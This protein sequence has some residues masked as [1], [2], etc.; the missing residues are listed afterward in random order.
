[1]RARVNGVRHAA[2][3]C[4]NFE[5]GWVFLDWIS[6][7]P[8]MLTMRR[9]R[10][11]RRC[12]CLIA[13]EGASGKR[14]TRGCGQSWYLRRKR[15][16]SL[17]AVISERRV[18]KPLGLQQRSV[19]IKKSDLIFFFSTKSRLS[20]PPQSWILPQQRFNIAAFLIRSLH[21]Q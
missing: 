21:P 1:M 6:L 7:K 5:L 10:L 8:S 11:H 17:I 4:L 14:G 3:L 16:V 18:Y 19:L 12:H 20:L 15:P 13:K 9:R 2:V